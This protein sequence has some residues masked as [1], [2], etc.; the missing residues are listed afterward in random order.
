METKKDASESKT[1]PL[2]AKPLQPQQLAKVVGGAG[3]GTATPG[4]IHKTGMG[5]LP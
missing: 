5:G 1:K 3:T 4:N 2:Q